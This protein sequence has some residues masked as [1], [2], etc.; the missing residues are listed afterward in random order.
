LLTLS[1]IDLL[2]QNQGRIVS[3]GS[4]AHAFAHEIRFSYFEKQDPKKYDRF[5]AYSHS[6]LAIIL[7][8]RQ[9]A[10]EYKGV[11]IN[12]VHPGVVATNI[13]GGLWFPFN[14]IFDF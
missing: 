4:A 2:R 14:K 11:T 3:V 13:A 12:C 5:F 1:L 7:F 6:K 8:V 10:K 9:L